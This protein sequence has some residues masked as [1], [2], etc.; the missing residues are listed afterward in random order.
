M[1]I[2]TTEINGTKI[3]SYNDSNIEWVVSSVGHSTLRFGKK[4]FTMKHAVEFYSELMRI[5]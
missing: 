3:E 1:R 5:V 2:H 4:E